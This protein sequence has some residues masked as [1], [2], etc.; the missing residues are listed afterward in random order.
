[1]LVP[2]EGSMI[3]SRPALGLLTAV[4]ATA[5][6]AL[7]AMVAGAETRA[8][9]TTQTVSSQR[10]ADGDLGAIPAEL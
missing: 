7:G 4:A 8:A 10:V 3:N 1:M 6:L 9:S 2:S 5:M